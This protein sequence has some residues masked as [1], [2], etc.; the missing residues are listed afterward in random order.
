MPLGRDDE[1]VAYALGS[2]CWGVLASLA[3]ISAHVCAPESCRARAH[4]P[5][6]PRYDN[7]DE[8]SNRKINQ[9]DPNCAAEGGVAFGLPPGMREAASPR[10]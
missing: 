1:G 9:S 3:S 6:T 10:T 8:K 4:A 2:L 5:R 7:S